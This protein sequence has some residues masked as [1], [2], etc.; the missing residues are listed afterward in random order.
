MS[1]RAEGRAVAGTR[2]PVPLLEAGAPLIAERR[3]LLIAADLLALAVGWLVVSRLVEDIPM[4]G[5]SAIL[6]LGT[7]LLSASVFDCYDL[8]IA[9]RTR[10]SV[11]AAAAALLTTLLVSTLVLRLS[12]QV[13]QDPST[14]ILWGAVAFAAVATARVIYSTLLTHPRFRRRV[15]IVGAAASARAAVDLLRNETLDYDLVGAVTP[16]APNGF[17]NGHGP[18]DVQVLGRYSDLAR[19]V[20]QHRVSEVILA[21]EDGIGADLGP[22]VLELYQAGIEVRHIN[23]LYEE[24][25]GK[26]AVSHVGANWLS[27]LPRR[28]GG[29]RTYGLVRR[30]IDVV[31]AGTLLL[32]LAPL[33]ALIALVIKVEGRGPVIYRQERVGRLGRHFMMLKFRT[34]V[35]DAE[36]GAALWAARRDPRRTRV[37]TVL[38]PTRL[39]ELPQLWN[40]FVGEMSLVGPRPE[41][42]AFIEVLERAIPHY[43][44]RLLV[45]PGITGWAQVR[46]PYAGSIDDSLAKLQYDLYYVKY[47]SPYLDLVI[48]LKTLGVLARASGR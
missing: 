44:A 41:R 34:M 26:I 22:G 33:M 7:W 47:R 19:V 25:T 48:A 30:V 23:E 9:A 4:Q 28:A 11:G 42:P 20:R 8:R 24:I 13:A 27:F 31:I 43:R 46:F 16:D 3:L 15:A 36:N 18:A 39:D 1:L 6:V 21:E 17:S 37:G 10:R 45:P 38:R 5:S 32:A 35:V 2:I 29:G 14:T 40:V 12:G